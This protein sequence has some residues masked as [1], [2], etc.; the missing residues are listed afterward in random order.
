MLFF[1][2]CI[3]QRT[4]SMIR[5]RS[6]VSIAARIVPATVPMES[7]VFWDDQRDVEL[8]KCADQ[9]LSLTMGSMRQKAADGYAVESDDTYMVAKFNRVADTEKL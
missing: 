2:P 9:E 8:L 6:S 3:S 5:E 1:T 4:S 7:F